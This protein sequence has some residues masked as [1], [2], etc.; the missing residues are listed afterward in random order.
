MGTQHP[1]D[2]RMREGPLSS[3]DLKSRSISKKFF[4]VRQGTGL[5]PPPAPQSLFVQ[6]TH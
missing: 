6:G 2:L 3:N 4:L 5:Y 1:G